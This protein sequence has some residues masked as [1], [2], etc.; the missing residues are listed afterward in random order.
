M[1]ADRS[2]DDLIAAARERP[3]LAP[4]DAQREGWQRLQKSLAAGAPAAFD[5]GPSAVAGATAAGAK[6]GFVGSAGK[7]IVV[8][9]LGSGATATAVVRATGAREE[10]PRA[11][12]VTDTPAPA[13]TV[14]TTRVEPARVAAPVAPT[15]TPAVE[16]VPLA[17]EVTAAL[18]TSPRPRAKTLNATS[19]TTETPAPKSAGTLDA[20]LSVIRSAQRA[21][22]DGDPQLAL[23]RLAVHAKTY[24]NGGM[25]EDRA[26]LTVLALCRAGRRSEGRAERSEFLAQWPKSMHAGRVRGACEGKAGG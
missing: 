22:A 7:W 15:A 19:P 14:A 9:M 25:K 4:A 13:T 2:I 18:T 17:P 11:T 21:L 1:T 26:A 10:T 23:D 16:P 6:A 3:P 8:A 20:E 24:P 12:V 5:L